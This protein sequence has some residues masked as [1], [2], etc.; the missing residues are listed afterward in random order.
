MSNPTIKEREMKFNI[1]SNDLNIKLIKR[2][3][4]SIFYMK[5]YIN[6]RENLTIKLIDSNLKNKCI[7]YCPE[8]PF[9]ISSFSS[10]VDIRAINIISSDVEKNEYKLLGV[11]SNKLVNAL[12]QL[13]M[14][15]FLGFF[16]QLKEEGKIE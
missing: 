9:G 13:G 2:T 12:K 7:D 15:H 1:L 4:N 6:N 5:E 8:L 3:R 14:S 11:K 10:Y 16:K